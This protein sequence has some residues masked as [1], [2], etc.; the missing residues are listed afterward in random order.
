VLE[1]GPHDPS[2]LSWMVGSVKSR[3]I[4][5]VMI[6]QAVFG[7]FTALAL[8]KRRNWD[9]PFDLYSRYPFTA[10]RRFSG[11]A[12]ISPSSLQHTTMED[13]IPIA[14]PSTPKLPRSSRRKHREPKVSLPTLPDEE[15]I[16]GPSEVKPNRSTRDKARRAEKRSERD[17][18]I[19]SAD[20]QW[21]GREWD[22]I[23]LTEGEVSRVPPIWSND[24]R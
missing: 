19:S 9:V 1:L 18:E 4:V 14:G 10:S 24:G 22:A 2:A 20:K 11:M 6:S 12:K 16:A 21:K 13:P 5:I 3:A 17:R 15:P 23:P 7:V 8:D